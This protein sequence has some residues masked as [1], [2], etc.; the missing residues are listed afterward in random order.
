MG[1]EQAEEQAVD[2]IADMQT[3]TVDPPPYAYDPSTGPTEPP[4][5]PPALRRCLDADGAEVQCPP[6]LQPGGVDT[7]Q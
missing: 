3:E 4:P 6:E 1:S 5:A 7:Q 2:Q